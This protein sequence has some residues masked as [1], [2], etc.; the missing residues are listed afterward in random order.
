MPKNTDQVTVNGVVF[1]YGDIFSVIDNFYHRV[2]M[3]AELKVPFQSVHDWPEHVA[4]LVHFWWIKF[5]GAPYLFGY[6]NPV[7]KHF[8]AGF[9]DQLLKRWKNIFGDVLKDHLKN[10]QAALW[11]QIVEQMGKSLTIKNESF[12]KEYDLS[13]PKGNSSNNP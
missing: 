12:K 7:A 3:D 13:N 1:E 10:E 2:Q 4:R 5:G 9:N 8:F 6:Y 11:A